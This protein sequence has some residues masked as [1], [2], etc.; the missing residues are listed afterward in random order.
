MIF[1][2][3]LPPGTG[4][5]AGSAGIGGGSSGGGSYGASLGDGARL[6]IGPV[7]SWSCC[8]DII[9]AAAA[10]A[11]GAG[12]CVC[13]I[14]ESGTRGGAGVAGACPALGGVA[15][16]AISGE[17]GGVTAGGAPETGSGRIGPEPALR[18]PNEAAERPGLSFSLVQSCIPRSRGAARRRHHAFGIFDEVL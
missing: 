18:R 1:L 15:T 6:P 8:D 12:P 14:V 13:G 5:A 7:K 4:A 3:L 9:G 11:A 2:R 17:A 10:G 16:A